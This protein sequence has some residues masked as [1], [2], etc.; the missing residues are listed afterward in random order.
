MHVDSGFGKPGFFTVDSI[1]PP[2]KKAKEA[3]VKEKELEAI[4]LKEFG[5]I[6]R[7]QYTEPKRIEAEKAAKDKSRGERL[8]VIDGYNLIF[9]WDMLNAIAQEDLDHARDMLMT[10][11][12]SYVAYTRCRLIL[13]FDAY[14]VKGNPGKEEP[15]D[16]Y[17]VVYTAEGET[18]DSRIQTLIRGFKK[19]SDV[20]VVTSDS[21]IQLSA[22]GAGV[23]RMSAREFTEELCRIGDEIREKLAEHAAPEGV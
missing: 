2:P 1:L 9:S 11:L 8:L 16:G 22:L 17:T 19:E 6:R 7:K 14:L 3:G 23:L 10:L 12:S 13:V 4:M 20:R 18:A 21:L 5:P 15:H